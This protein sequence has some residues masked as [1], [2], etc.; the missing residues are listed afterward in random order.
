MVDLVENEI[1]AR[2]I[3]DLAEEINKYVGRE[4]V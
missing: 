4:Q 2:F 1:G 3:V